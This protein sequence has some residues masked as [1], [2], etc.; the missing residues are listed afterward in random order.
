MSDP[1]EKLSRRVEGDPLFLASVLAEYARAEG[2][3]DAGLAQALG[4]RA[5][6]LTGLRL[7]RAPRAEP[8]GFREDCRQ[9]AGRFGLDMDRLMG[10][11]RQGEALRRLRQGAVG[12][13]GFLMAARDRPEGPPPPEE[14]QRP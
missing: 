5:E 9:I 13:P 11:V 3:D 2:R 8:A 12:P 6:D 10:V 7:C 1:L 4:C 14:E